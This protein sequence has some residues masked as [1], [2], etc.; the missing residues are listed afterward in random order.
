MYVKDFTM[1]LIKIKR[2]SPVALH[3][4]KKKK[5]KESFSFELF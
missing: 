4:E 2:V 3:F 5:S 1:R